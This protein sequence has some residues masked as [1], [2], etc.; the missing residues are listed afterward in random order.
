MAIQE[1][2]YTVDDVW[3][4][5]HR[6]ENHDKYYYLIDGELYWDMPPGGEHGCLASELI[7]RLMSFAE[8]RE[9][10]AFTVESGYYPADDR[11][12]VLAPD[13]AF[14]SKSRAPQ[15]LPKKYVPAMPDLAIEI[16][17][18]TDTLS[19]VRRKAAVYLANGTSLVWIVL[20]A[21]QGVEVC[22]ASDS[23]GLD[24][25]FVDREGS[26]SGEGIL[27]GFELKLKRLFP[28]V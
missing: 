22:R 1:K 23:G 4:L 18:P 25:E 28:D 8:G 10:G 15:P 27:P 2:L 14:I 13:I 3:E 11:H 16:M 12:T 17:S 9:L 5:S 21:K 7:F 19:E 20:P 26:L 24:I 6:P